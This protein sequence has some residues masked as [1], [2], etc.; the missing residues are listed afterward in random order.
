MV[1]LYMVTWIP[2]IYP[3]YVSIYTYIYIYIP[4]W[5]YLPSIYGNMDPINLPYIYQHH[6]SY[7]YETIATGGSGLAGLRRRGSSWVSSSRC[8]RASLRAQPFDRR[9]WWL[10]WRRS[11]GPKKGPKKGQLG[12]FGNLQNLSEFVTL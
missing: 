12:G 7:G 5:V 8:S 11:V 1:L 9:I 2:S 6:G 4:L 10:R 3:I